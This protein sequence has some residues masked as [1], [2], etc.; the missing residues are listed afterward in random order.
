MVAVAAVE[1]DLFESD[2]CETAEDAGG[3]RATCG[4]DDA[5]A[6]GCNETLAEGGDLAALYEHICARLRRGAGGAGV[7]GRVA[8]QQRVGGEGHRGRERRECGR[9]GR[10]GKSADHSDTPG[11]AGWPSMKSDSGKARRAPRSKRIAPSMNTC[12]VS[13]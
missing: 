13:A 8:D 2:S 4:V 6:G 5:R 11:A 1:A 3:D 9:E 7:H 10:D 12:S